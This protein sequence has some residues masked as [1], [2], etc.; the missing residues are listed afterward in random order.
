MFCNSEEVA[1]LCAS[2]VVC[3]IEP[4]LFDEPIVTDDSY[5]YLSNQCLL[6]VLSELPANTIFQQEGV[7]PLYCQAVGDLLVGKC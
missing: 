1:I 2:S 6:S 5:L 3:V 7:P 4:Y